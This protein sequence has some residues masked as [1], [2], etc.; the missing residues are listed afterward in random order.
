M[1]VT[2]LSR[3]IDADAEAVFETVSDISNFSR[4]VPHIVRVEYLSDVKVGVGAR[5]RET[6]LM[7]GREATTELE[8]AEFVKNERVRMISDAG[9][10]IWDTV[11][12]VAPGENGRGTRLDMVM[13]ARPHRFMAKLAGPLMKGMIAKAI[14]ED[15]DAIKAYCE[16][17][18]S[19]AARVSA[20]GP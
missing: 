7:R 5:F 2:K 12:T 17:G 14:G 13:E 3:T 6:R 8:V 9:G 4:A 10:T 15:L 20:T 19:T 1:A 16:G 11:F 18:D